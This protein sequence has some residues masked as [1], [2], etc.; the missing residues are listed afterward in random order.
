MPSTRIFEHC[1]RISGYYL[2]VWYWCK[3]W[4]YRV[5][6]L[7]NMFKYCPAVLFWSTFL[8]FIFITAKY[9]TNFL[10]VN[11]SDFF[12]FLLAILSLILRINCYILRSNCN[13][14]K[15][16]VCKYIPLWR[17]DIWRYNRWCSCFRTAKLLLLS[18]TDILSYTFTFECYTYVKISS[19]FYKNV[20]FILIQCRPTKWA[21]Y[22]LI[23]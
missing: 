9:I 22:K 11:L 20:S 15:I 14:Y 2:G 13:I 5:L 16:Y 6:P 7:Q 18:L 10:C 21:F 3:M 8:G 12:C 17:R 23:L 19:K 1:P 4:S